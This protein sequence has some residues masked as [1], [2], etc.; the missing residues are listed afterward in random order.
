[1]SIFQIRSAHIPLL[2]RRKMATIP[3]GKVCSTTFAA[4]GHDGLSGGKVPWLIFSREHL[5]RRHDLQYQCERCWHRFKPE[6][7]MT[8]HLRAVSGCT[9]KTK[10][11]SPDDVTPQQIKQWKRRKRDGLSH[12][13]RWNDMFKTLF[14]MIHDND[15]PSPCEFWSYGTERPFQS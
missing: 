7:L 11:E 12:V 10:V 8:D 3:S 9:L 5:F 4:R 1:M 2:R 15:M 13:D 14:P 6:D